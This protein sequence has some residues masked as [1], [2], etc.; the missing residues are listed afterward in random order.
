MPTIRFHAE[1]HKAWVTFGGN[2]KAERS[3]GR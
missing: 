2:G 1:C 3:L